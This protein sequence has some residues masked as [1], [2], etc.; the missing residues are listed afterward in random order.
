MKTKQ[1]SKMKELRH[2]HGAFRVLCLSVATIT[3]IV[4][5][6]ELLLSFC[7]MMHTEYTP[8][9]SSFYQDRY[10]WSL[11][12]SISPVWI[13]LCP[14]QSPVQSLF[15]LHLCI[16]YLI[17]T[18]IYLVSFTSGSSWRAAWKRQSSSLPSS[19][20]SQQQQEFPNYII[21]YG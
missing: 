9:S 13:S 14:P 19:P 3:F 8:L 21:N 2:S 7:Q 18:A 4:I 20:L 5:T 10:P 11:R 16:T 1:D 6:H 17:G 12:L 15:T